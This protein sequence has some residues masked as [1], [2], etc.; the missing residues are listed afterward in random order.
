VRGRVRTRHPNS[1]ARV[2]ERRRQRVCC[3]ARVRGGVARRR[4]CALRCRDALPRWA[5]RARR[6]PLFAFVCAR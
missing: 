4:A 1:P 3:A 5:V 2:R 6:L